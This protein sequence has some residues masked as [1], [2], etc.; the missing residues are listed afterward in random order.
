MK[1]KQFFKGYKRV[2]SDFVLRIA[3]LSSKQK[4]SIKG[5]FPPPGYGVPSGANV[6]EKFY[7]KT[8]TKYGLSLMRGKIRSQPLYYYLI[9]FLCFLPTLL[10]SFKPF[11]ILV[12]PVMVSFYFL[13]TH[14]IYYYIDKY[15]MP[16]VLTKIWPCW[17]SPCYDL[18]LSVPHK[19]FIKKSDKNQKEYLYWKP[20]KQSSMVRQTTEFSPETQNLQEVL[21]N[22]AFFETFFDNKK[23]FIRSEESTKKQAR[24]SHF[25]NVGT[26]HDG[27]GQIRKG[28]W[29]WFIFTPIWTQYLLIWLSLM[30][31]LET[32]VLKHFFNK[33]SEDY[34]FVTMFPYNYIFVIMIWAVGSIVYLNRRMEFLK[35]LS[36]QVEDGVFEAQLEKVPQAVLAD[37]VNIPTHQQVLSAINY[38]KQ[39]TTVIGGVA[40][41][42]FIG[43][44]DVLGG[45]NLESVKAVDPLTQIIEGFKAVMFNSSRFIVFIK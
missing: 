5:Y 25:N 30:F 17:P 10:Y 44:L 9:P 3:P 26:L 11:D 4:K 42:S 22:F 29:F 18:F 45:I 19:V 28:H 16:V 38:L 33:G 41:F 2:R 27:E 8:D 37:M 40:L 1:L 32:P 31:I 6:D 43:A 23:R 21:L 39:T 15:K 34:G 7:Y 36:K 35:Q 24:A 12:Y 14:G 20:D 13:F